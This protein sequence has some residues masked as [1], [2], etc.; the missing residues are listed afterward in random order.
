MDTIG[1]KNLQT[2]FFL[3]VSE[4]RPQIIVSDLL[5][6]FVSWYKN[7]SCVPKMYVTLCLFSCDGT[8]STSEIDKFLKLKNIKY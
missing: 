2:Y 5:K 3:N 7:V 1:Y 8:Y 4:I 6:I